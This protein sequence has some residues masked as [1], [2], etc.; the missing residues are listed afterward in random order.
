MLN[1]YKISSIVRDGKNTIVLVHFYEGDMQK[2]ETFD[3]L[4]QKMV[5]RNVYVRTKMIE[6]QKIGISGD[7]TDED[8]VVYMNK[9]LGKD[10]KKTPI[11]EQIDNG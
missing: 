6:E 5:K 3:K 8:L 7:L 10:P 9:K 2:V 4:E 1:D 11:P